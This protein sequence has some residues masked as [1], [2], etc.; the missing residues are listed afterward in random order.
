MNER[1]GIYRESFHLKLCLKTELF[2]LKNSKKQFCPPLPTLRAHG[3]VPK[4]I[5]ATLGLPKSIFFS[6]LGSMVRAW[7]TWIMLEVP[8]CIFSV[9][10]ACFF[11]FLGVCFHI[12]C[13]GTWEHSF[14]HCNVFQD[15]LNLHSWSPQSLHKSSNVLICRF[16]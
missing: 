13:L 2:P 10:T 3:S 6:H 1:S 9:C 16:A 15:L 5:F 4:C 14:S 7:G 12:R 8:Q 11:V